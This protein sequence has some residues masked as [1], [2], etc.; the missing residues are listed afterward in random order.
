MDIKLLYK[1]IFPKF[2][3]VFIKKK[4]QN[5][6]QTNNITMLYRFIYYFFRKR[7]R[8]LEYPTD[9]F[10]SKNNFTIATHIS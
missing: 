1:A 8:F 10:L 6:N 9:C 2:D 4:N 3:Y 7:G 5:E